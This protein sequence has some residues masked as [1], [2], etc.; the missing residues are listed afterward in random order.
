MNRLAEY[1][2]T[3]LRARHGR[4]F[5]LVLLLI[6]TLALVFHEATPL[7]NLRHAQFDH[8][9]QLM[10]RLRDNEPVIVVSVD[11]QSLERH[12]QWPWS[13]ELMAQLVNQIMAGQPLAVGI[14]MIFAE[15]D[16]YSPEVLAERLPALSKSALA[17]LNE[18]DSFFSKALSQ[19]PTVLAVVGVVG[20]ASTRRTAATQAL[21]GTGRGQSRRTTDPAFSRRFG[22]STATGGR[23]RWRG[24]D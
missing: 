14:D 2:T 1:A 16:R 7:A 23:R 24:S 4:A 21:A 8:Y 18:P 5:P 17:G 19:G 13:R 11:S 22:Q 12:G 15:R 9:Q 6:A 3:L 20:Q 10:P